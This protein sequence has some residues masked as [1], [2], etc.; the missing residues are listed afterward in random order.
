MRKPATTWA[1]LVILLSVPAGKAAEKRRIPC[2]TPANALSCYWT[3]GRLA[4]YNGTPAYRLWKVGTHRLLGIYSGPSVDRLSLDNE[5]PELPASI[6][7]VYDPAVG[8]L[9]FGDFEV[10]PLEPEVA[11]AMQA[12]CIESARN[13]LL[14]R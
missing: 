1:L 11:G 8:G 6:Y 2:K 10:C 3:H 7:R 12:A 14:R 9:L 5:N 13:L 4:F